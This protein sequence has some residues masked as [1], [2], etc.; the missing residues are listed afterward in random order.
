MDGIILLA[1]FACH[2][3][4]IRDSRGRRRLHTIRSTAWLAVATAIIVI[5]SATASTILVTSPTAAQS[6]E[7]TIEATTTE[8]DAPAGAMAYEEQSIELHLE[9]NG[10]G[11]G[12]HELELMGQ[13]S[14]FDETIREFTVEGDSGSKTFYLSAEELAE[15]RDIHAEDMAH[16]FVRWG[17]EG[18][19]NVI[20]LWWQETTVYTTG[21]VPD[22]VEP[23]EEITIEYYGWTTQSDAHVRLVEDDRPFTVATAGT[24]EQI[25]RDSVS[26]P[27][28][29]EGSFTFTP[30]DYVGDG[31]GREIEI[32][33]RPEDGPSNPDQRQSIT[34]DEPQ[35][36][37]DARILDFSPPSGEYSEGEDVTGQVEVENTG[38]TQHRFFVGYSVIDEDETIYHNGGTTGKPVTLEPGERTTVTV[39]WTVE[40]DAP[41]GSYDTET[42]VW[43]EDDPSA[44]ETQLDYTRVENNFE[45]GSADTDQSTNTDTTETENAAQDEET[46]SSDEGDEATADTEEST[47][48]TESTAE[49]IS[50]DESAETSLS[51]EETSGDDI[52]DNPESADEGDEETTAGNEEETAS[53][54]EEPDTGEDDEASMTENAPGFGIV[55][56]IIALCL[57]GGLVTVRY[58]SS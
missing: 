57:A 11:P 39:S 45:V 47:S 3:I 15:T 8:T 46:T 7:L 21:S 44:F 28:Y 32:Q 36:E 31:E 1:P 35:T 25:R 30:S 24:D 55:V 14:A 38:N 4:M 2:A 5:V 29:F 17:E 26:G 51:D 9:Y 23:G 12:T 40:E 52:A 53:N 34:V 56:A 48:D 22:A 37:I 13:D 16:L 6:S 43:E 49:E 10:L 41:P 20:G 58:R 50:S 27:G 19:S 42:A 18:K 54:E 33:A